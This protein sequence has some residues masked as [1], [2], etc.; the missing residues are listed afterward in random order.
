MDKL[1]NFGVTKFFKQIGTRG[2]KIPQWAL[3]QNAYK[4]KQLWYNKKLYTCIE[5]STNTATIDING[6]ITKVHRKEILAPKNTIPVYKQ[7]TTEELMQQVRKL[8]PDATIYIPKAG[9]QLH[10]DIDATLT[11]NGIKHII[12]WNY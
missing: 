11:I 6:I 4:G 3:K 1:T 5:S 8:Y 12:P 7:L 9:C 2:G 10:G